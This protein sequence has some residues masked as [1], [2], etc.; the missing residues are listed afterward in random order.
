MK[1]NNIKDTLKMQSS[2]RID[3]N[4]RIEMRDGTILRADIY[5][6]YDRRKH[7][8][9]LIRTP[10]N[11]FL[12]IDNDY[13]GLIEVVLAGY[14]AVVQDIRGRF[15]SDGKY[16]GSDRFL[17]QEGPDGYDSVEWIASQPWCDGNV[18]MAGGSAMGRLQWVAAKENPP[19][20]KAIAPAIIGTEPVSEPV[21][22]GGVIGLNV[23]LSATVLL[24][25]DIIDK[26]EKKGKDVSLIRHMLNRAM[27]NPEEVY[28]YL[29]LKDIPH[30][31]FE[32]LTEFWKAR[33]V[34]AVPNQESARKL[35]FPFQKVTVPCLHFSGW[36]DI[37]AWG[38]FQ[39]FLNMR[40][41][42][43]S[44]TARK[45][46]HI[47]MGPWAHGY[48]LMNTIGDINF[49]AFA[50]ARG[51]QVSAQHIAFFNKYLEGIDL[52][53]PAVRYFVMGQNVWKNADTWP[54]P[55][56]EW[57]RFFLHSQGQANT[58][59]GDGL[60]SRDESGREPPDTF[61]YNPLFP[62]PIMG[63]PRGA[64]NGFV[65]GPLEQS[66]IEKRSDVLCYTTPELK[67]DLE[68]TGPL[69]LHL[70]AA[71]SVRDTDFVAKLID[72]YPDGR[73]YNVAEGVMRA[74]FRKSILSPEL[75]IPGEINEYV[76]KMSYSSQL[77]RKGHS[78]RIDITSSNFPA[79]DRNMNTGN[80]VGEDAQGIVAEQRIFHEPKFSSYIDLPVVKSS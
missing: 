55:Q 36:Y 56:T 79:Y 29:P 73:A 59:S 48:R 52:K 11:K 60:L 54:L 57:Q 1:I 50:D 8:A 47:V 72:V 40:E 37:H 51:A 38:V 23:E 20:L 71:T 78:I 6:P 21:L 30:F 42:G 66:L 43:G 27:Q 63:G 18:G 33:V 28:N 67:T 46:Q 58:A 32:G 31:N 39:S 77:F 3:R 70:F 15:A 5:R 41:K 9:I 22:L 76:I 14:A 69:E 64:A 25:M 44:E 49:G 2:I 13:P 62:V 7:P 34:N 68:V 65:A 12:I 26:Q 61:L 45:S 35:G 19:H 80:A 10:Y 17:T 74:R 75:V 24:G 4:V 16:D 53:I